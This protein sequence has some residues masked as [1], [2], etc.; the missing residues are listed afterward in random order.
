MIEIRSCK[1]REA[2]KQSVLYTGSMNE[3]GFI[4]EFLMA[5]SFTADC[6][7]GHVTMRLLGNVDIQFSPNDMILR[8]NSGVSVMSANAF[9]EKYEAL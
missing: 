9:N 1:T 5:T 3:V 7:T 6:M 2:A 8:S 4:A